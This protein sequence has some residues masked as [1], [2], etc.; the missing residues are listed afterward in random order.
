MLYSLP[1]IEAIM[2]ILIS[3]AGPT[4]TGKL[5]DEPLCVVSDFVSFL[6]GHTISY[7]EFSQGIVSNKTLLKE[8]YEPACSS[9]ALQNFEALKEIASEQA[10]QGLLTAHQVKKGKNKKAKK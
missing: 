6:S 5:K 4:A 8:I 2:E 9:H 10:P 7:L 3:K 1:A